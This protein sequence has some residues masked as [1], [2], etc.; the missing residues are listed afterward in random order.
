MNVPPLG[1]P[2][3]AEIRKT[4]DRIRP[5][6]HRTPVM[7]CSAIN[8]MVGADLFFKCEN[9]QKVG[10]FKF[11]GATNAVLML[12]DKAAPRGVATVSSG[13]HA[14]GL[15]LAARARGIP[16]YVVMPDNSAR[17]K[18]DAV[19]GYGAHI[20]FCAPT[21]EAREQAVADLVERTGATLVHPYNDYRIIAGQATATLELIEDTP[22]L[23]VVMTP[24]GGG[25][26]TSGASL[27]VHY[28]SPS[29]KMIAAEPEGANDAFRSF[30]S[31]RI[32]PSENPTTIADGLRSSL[33]EKT[34]PI[35][36]EF[37][38]DIVT[39]SEDGIVRAMRTI[40]ERMKIIVEPSAAV[41]LGALLEGRV[42]VSG[43]R[44]GIIL[45]GGNVDLEQLP[46]LAKGA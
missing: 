15:S 34:F 3:L 30:H 29:T 5:H 27:V 23:D 1:V 44:V 8:G 31:G 19:A 4:A 16:A 26:L 37:V 9:L 42:P 43:K 39:V 10:A 17:V 45:S 40:W 11:R 33:G 12:D 24:I 22:G 13:N 14:A 38:D 41:P 36:Q 46:W 32:V 35:I 21:M 18:I 25:G 2:D 7:T 20:I 6:V 28:C